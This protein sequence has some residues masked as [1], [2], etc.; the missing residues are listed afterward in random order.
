MPCSTTIRSKVELSALD[1]A[2]NRS[3][4]WP[5]LDHTPNVTC[6][7]PVS[8]AFKAAGDPDQK[9][10]QK[11]LINALS[12]NTLPMPIYS[13]YLKDGMEMKSVANLTVRISVNSGGT[14]FN[15]AKVVQQNVL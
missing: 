9:L 13:N 6:L 4:I 1:N 10:N 2:L 14:W 7:A 11:D 3:G 8:A 15:D 12:F 5:T